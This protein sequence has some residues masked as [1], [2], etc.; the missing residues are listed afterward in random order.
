MCDYLDTFSDERIP[1]CSDVYDYLRTLNG[2][3]TLLVPNM[4]CDIRKH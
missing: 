4:S 1:V 2:E 3:F